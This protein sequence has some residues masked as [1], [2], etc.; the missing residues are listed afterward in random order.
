VNLAVAWMQRLAHVFDD[1]AVSPVDLT[2][3]LAVYV[4]ST[5]V[6]L[7]YAKFGDERH[8]GPRVAMRADPIRAL[9]ELRSTVENQLACLGQKRNPVRRN[10]NLVLAPEMYHLSLVDRPDVADDEVVEAVRWQIQD[11][12]DFPMESACLDVFELPRSASRERRMVFAVSVQKEL[13]RGLLNQLSS[14]GLKASSIDASELVLRNL[15]WQCFPQPDQNIAMLRLTAT[16]GLLNISRADELYLARRISGVPADFSDEKWHEFRER[17]LLQ[18]QRS[19][20]Y[21][22]SAMNQPHCNMLVV[23]CTDDWTERVSEYLGEMLPIPVRTIDEVLAGELQITL[24]SPRETAVDWSA[25]DA[26]M[27]NAIAAG[28][29]AVGGLLR[30]RIESTVAE[31]A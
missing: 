23:M 25:L 7:S 24:F 6:A 16:S 28:L 8:D 21:Y 17:L 29:P 13:L 12:V 9:S 2:E 10:V 19:I 31:L 27:R 15:A 30:H 14:A 26:G 5:M 20:D 18:V 11:Q 22:E 3:Q 4:S 1:T